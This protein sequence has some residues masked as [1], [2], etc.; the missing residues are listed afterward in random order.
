ML[1]RK[2]GNWQILIKVKSSLFKFLKIFKYFSDNFKLWK[3]YSLWK[4][5]VSPEKTWHVYM[6][7]LFS[8]SN[9][10]VITQKKNPSRSGISLSKIKIWDN[11]FRTKWTLLCWINIFYKN[12]KNRSQFCAI[13]FILFLHVMCSL[14]QK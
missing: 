4:N 9:F 14:L 2:L 12:S 11:K 10:D 8:V 1:K 7:V 13:N 3:T 5:W 6:V